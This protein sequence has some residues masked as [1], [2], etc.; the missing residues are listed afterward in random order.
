MTCDQAVESLPL[1]LYGELTAETEESLEAHLHLCPECR[2]ALDFHQRLH[3]R[4]DDATVDPP[5][6]LLAECRRDLFRRVQDAAPPARTGWRGR[7]SQWMGG[8]PALAPRL[9]GAVALLAVGFLGARWSDSRPSPF[10]PS[11]PE[12]LISTVRSVQ[13]GPEGRVQIA[14]DETR[15]RQ[16]SG[17]LQDDNIERLL[18]AA[19]RDEANTGLRVE[20]I[21]LLGKLPESAEVRSALIHAATYD[22]NPGVRLKALQGLKDMAADAEV[23]QTLARVLQND[24]NPGVRILAIDLLVQHRDT[25]LVGLLQKLVAREENS[26]VRMRCRNALEEMNASV[27]T[28]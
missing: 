15:R 2:E 21:D 8:I 26:Y 1:Y 25:A 20:T 4:V 13:P 6:M 23:R 18:L 11:S 14:F 16:V 12:P 24:S 28:F 19:V 22:A 7:W 27:G 5:P 17:S 10:L 3:Q 9:A